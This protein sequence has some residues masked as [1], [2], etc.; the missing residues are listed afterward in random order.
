MWALKVTK[1]LDRQGHSRINENCKTILK[2]FGMYVI[3][4]LKLQ[5][6]SPGKSYQLKT[7]TTQ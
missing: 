1:Y 6:H 5:I 2:T 4:P 3:L 7:D